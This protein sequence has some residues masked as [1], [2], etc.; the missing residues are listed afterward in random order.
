MSEQDAPA[1]GEGHATGRPA[2]TGGPGAGS[3]GVPGGRSPSGA[4]SP[5]TTAQD[6]TTPEGT[7]LQ[8]DATSGAPVARRAS[9][10]FPGVSPPASPH[11]IVCRKPASS[12]Q[13]NTTPVPPGSSFAGAS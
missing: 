12:A 13:S 9:A 4:T 3:A 11:G 10:T 7:D 1:G 2:A 8:A 5:G 6:E